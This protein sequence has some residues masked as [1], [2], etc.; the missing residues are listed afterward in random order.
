MCEYHGSAAVVIPEWV[1][2]YHT[3]LYM[4]IVYQCPRKED[5]N[6]PMFSAYLLSN[7]NFEIQIA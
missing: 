6:I 1:G 4:L 5:E 7:S 2:R 3:F